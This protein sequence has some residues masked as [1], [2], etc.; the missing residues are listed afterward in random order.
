[1]PMITRTNIT[2]PIPIP[3]LAPVERPLLLLV[4]EL[5]PVGDPAS[6]EAED[7]SADDLLLEGE[8]L[9]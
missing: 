1:M 4:V 6:V 5:V 2:E 7:E 9:V 8:E 3:A